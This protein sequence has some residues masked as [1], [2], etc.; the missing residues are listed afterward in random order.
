MLYFLFVYRY[1][2]E[3]RE[4]GSQIDEVATV[5]WEGVSFIT[6]FIFIVNLRF[7]SA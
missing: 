5:L 7:T 2:G 1:S 3:M 6:I 4:I